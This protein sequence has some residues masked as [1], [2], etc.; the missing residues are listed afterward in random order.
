MQQ[1][2]Q[3]KTTKKQQHSIGLCMVHTQKYEMYNTVRCM[4]FTQQNNMHV[5]QHQY[6]HPGKHSL[7]IRLQPPKNSQGM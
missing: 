5:S 1:Q 7:K 4:D 3:R 2:N 6:I